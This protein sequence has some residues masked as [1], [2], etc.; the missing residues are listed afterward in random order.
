MEVHKIM[1]RLVYISEVFIVEAS[2]FL[3]GS[4]VVFVAAEATVFLEICS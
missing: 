2:P 1:T 4:S 3:A